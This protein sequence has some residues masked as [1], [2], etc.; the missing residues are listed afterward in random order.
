MGGIGATKWMK[1][2]GQTVNDVQCISLNMNNGTRTTGP[3]LFALI[4]TTKKRGSQPMDKP[5][6]AER[7]GQTM[8]ITPQR[9]KELE[10]A[11]LKL[12][13]LENGGVDDWT[14]YDDAMKEVQAQIEIED[15]LEE[16]FHEIEAALSEGAYEP[17]ERGAGFAFTTEASSAA[18]EIFTKGFYKLAEK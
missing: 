14:Y 16:L 4:A 1:I 5:K 11:E 18:F 3:D 10:R 12:R 13:A 6:T 7:K 15:G 9:L 17:S 8:K 2:H